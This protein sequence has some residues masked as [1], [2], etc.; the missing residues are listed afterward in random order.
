MSLIPIISCTPKSDDLET[1][2][3]ILAT[4][5][6][7]NLYIS[8][9]SPLIQTEATKEDSILYSNSLVEKWV[10]ETVLLYEAEKNIPADLDIK[11]M[12]NDYRSSLIL[13][14]YQQKLVHEKLDTLVTKKQLED[15]F[16]E[17][18]SQ[19]K[20]S[21]PI[22]NCI[23]LKVEKESKSIKKIESL[24]KAKKYNEIG[25]IDIEEF[26]LKLTDENQWYAWKDI[27]ALLPNSLWSFSEL[28]AKDFKSKTSG[29][30]NYYIKV[31]DYK[32]EN[33]I[34]PLSYIE[35]QITKLILH[36]RQTDLLNKVTE[37]LYEKYSKNNNI[38]INI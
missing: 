34:P 25:E 27:K 38:Q 8:D 16:D 24:W 17:N 12:V 3:P 20:L 23:F 26:E 2:N 6:D 4:V 9:I 30:Y 21:E 10:R 13:M 1:E 19:Y 36:R 32:D 33:Q 7:K 37:E 5:F 28:K 15:Y 14:N 31:F 22:V 18:S 35:D 29:N 11:K